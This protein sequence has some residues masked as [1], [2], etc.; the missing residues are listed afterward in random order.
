[1]STDEF[2]VVG[3]TEAIAIWPVAAFYIEDIKRRIAVARVGDTLYAFDDLC[4]LDRCSLSSGLL[5]PDLDQIMCQ[6]GGCHYDVRTGA[7]M[8]GPSTQGLSTYEVR[9]V[10]DQIEIR[11]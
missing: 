9:Q 7:V 2:R 1:M 10:G 4:T 3:D 11:I 5:K 6:C 8:R